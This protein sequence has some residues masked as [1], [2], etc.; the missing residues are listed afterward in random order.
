MLLALS[1]TADFVVYIWGNLTC[2]GETWGAESIFCLAFTTVSLFHSFLH[3]H[4]CTLVFSAASGFGKLSACHAL[5]YKKER[6]FL[7]PCPD[8]EYVVQG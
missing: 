4:Y 5:S 3:L 8:L 1:L 6:L 7:F 2:T